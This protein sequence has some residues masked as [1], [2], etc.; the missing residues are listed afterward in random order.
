MHDLAIIG[1]GWAGYNAA[2]KAKE[3]GLKVCLIENSQVGGTCLNLGCI[4]TKTL[5]QSAKI[6][7]L[8]KKSAS[9]GVETQGPKI[10]LA[11]V[12][13]RKDKVV[14]LLRSGMQAK[15]KDIDL[16]TGAAGIISPD[17]IKVGSQ[18]IET[19]N[20]LIAT[21]SRP[22]E[23]A[24]LKFDSK[25][26]ISSNEALNLKA[27][28]AR[29][30]IVGGGV[31]GCE[32]ASLYSTL[33]SQVT[34][35]EKMPQLLPGIDSEVAKKIEVIFK[36]KKIAVSTNTDASSFKQSDFDLILVC[37]GRL[38][39]TE[40][41]NLQNIGLKTDKNKVVV[42]EYL[43]TS[44]PNIFAAGD[45]TGKLMLAHYAAYQGV[46]AAE[47][48]ANPQTMKKADNAVVPSCIFSDPEIASVG[49]NE[50]EAKNKGIEVSVKKFDFLASGM[51]RIIDEAEGFIK[52]VCEAKTGRLIG[53]SIIGPKATELISIFG[54]AISNDLTAEQIKHTIFAH[55]SLSESIRESL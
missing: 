42:D 13:E 37:V 22:F 38:P 3:L 36:K 11:K 2:I 50:E 18:S 31:I 43:R 34:I 54:L 35:A 51:A 45:C 47:N 20:I 39:N 30:L 8:V 40:S 12:Q 41:L 17:K 32:F 7:S 25:K 44:I 48:I 27:V 23:L 24:Q 14:Q 1:A 4:P 28:P 6:F 55:P 33:G 53:A 10:N 52:T 46:I 21:G 16:L 29:L 9:F 5:I 15:L 19:K 49:V 26:I